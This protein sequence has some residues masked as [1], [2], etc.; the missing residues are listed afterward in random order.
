MAISA[1]RD[2]CTP[3]HSVPEVSYTSKKTHTPLPF[4]DPPETLKVNNPSGLVRLPTQLHTFVYE[5]AQDPSEFKLSL[6][7]KYPE[8]NLPLSQDLW[9]RTKYPL[10]DLAIL[11]C[12][13]STVYVDKIQFCILGWQHQGGRA[14][15]PGL[16]IGAL[17]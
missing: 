6:T 15:L 13:R 9:S 1:R 8:E 17:Y 3:R 10:S 16:L 7:P 4:L 5:D 2:S 11:L 14:F 12:D